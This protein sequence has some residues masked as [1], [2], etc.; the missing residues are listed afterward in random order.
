M[1]PLWK[2][3][4]KKAKIDYFI[5]NQSPTTV[6]NQSFSNFLSLY[7]IIKNPIV[8]FFFILSN[9]TVFYKKIY[10]K[11]TFFEIFFLWKNVIKFLFLIVFPTFYNRN[12]INN[13]RNFSRIFELIRLK[14]IGGDVCLVKLIC[15][16]F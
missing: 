9:N 10:K 14:N 12:C 4:T 2:A 16:P 6:F 7:K 3:Q 11:T 5:K 15:S 13:Q 8:G 1:G